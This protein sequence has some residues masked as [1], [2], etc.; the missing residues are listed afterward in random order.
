MYL[1]D[2]IVV[3]ELRKPKPHGAVLALLHGVD[4]TRLLV[5]VVTLG[6]IQAGIELTRE[7]DAATA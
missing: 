7:Q 6:G 2:T 4:D 5:S 3:S 1:L